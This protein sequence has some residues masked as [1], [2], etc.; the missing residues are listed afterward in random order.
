MLTI[1]PIQQAVFEGIH[2]AQ[3]AHPVEPMFSLA[4]LM[5]LGEEEAAEAV[6]GRE[7][8]IRFMTEYP[9]DHC[10][11]PPDWWLFLLLL[12]ERRLELPGAVLEEMISGGI[13]AGKSFIM[14]M[15]MVA[16]WKFTKRADIFCL[17]GTQPTSEKLQQQ[18]FEK[19][20]PREAL[21][22]E[23]G[24][25]KQTKHE[26][27][28]FS[29]GKFTDNK[30]TRFIQV[31]DE[32]GQV[33]RGGGSVEFKMFSQ[34]PEL[35]KGYSLTSVWWDEKC[36]VILLEKCY[37]RI[38][39][40]AV[41]TRE[42]WH[43]EK[44]LVLHRQLEDLVAGRS[45]QRPAT[46]LLGALMHGVMMGS[47]TPEEGYVATVRRYLQGSTKP[48]Q[49]KRIAAE[50]IDKPGVSDPRVPVVAFSAARNRLV[51]YLHTCANRMVDSYTELSRAAADWD[52]RTIRIKLY[53]DAEASDE[54]CFSGFTPGHVQP[55]ANVPSDMTLYFS[56][57]PAP[58]K[59]WS[60][61]L[62][63]VDA[64][65]R[66]WCLMEWPSPGVLV[67]VGDDSWLDPG[68]WAAPTG[69]EKLNG[70]KGPAAKLRLNYTFK[71]YTKLMHEMLLAAY[72]KLTAGGRKWLGG[73]DDLT[74]AWEDGYEVKGPRVRVERVIGDKRYLGATER[75]G[76]D[77]MTNLDWLLD[78]EHAFDWEVHKDDAQ[79][80]GLMAIS[81]VLSERAGGLPGL[82]VVADKD[83]AGQLRSGCLDTVFA[84]NTYTT[85]DGK[86]SPPRGDEA[87]KEAIDRLRYL[88]KCGVEY[89]GNSDDGFKCYGGGSY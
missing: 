74:L 41:E 28:K 29:G 82:L 33:Y 45:Q 64:L 13:R 32:Q 75:Q 12:C 55:W 1:D 17:S 58:V 16:H 67:R 66:V 47:Y 15:L 27:A 53:G 38:I 4:E 9:L 51:G 18:P 68:A 5:A 61:G 39:S 22:G 59:P 80:V 89:V 20:L 83:A 19:F 60:I 49:Y 57:D 3:S 24:A 73:V 65:G 72:V 23:K 42:T 85:E 87:C 54:R 2:E 7:E 77:V 79:G 31:T 25:I 14:A 84:L 40:R 48:D 70:D 76:E 88:L 35:F 11:V 43:R 62:Y 44:M 78:E 50:L 63:G 46:A 81:R 69:G 30:F 52:E 10:W 86:D 37:D 8:K 21:G 56:V 71:D 26:K 6:N 36:P 34:D